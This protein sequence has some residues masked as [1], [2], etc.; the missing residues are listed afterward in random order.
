MQ[1]RLFGAFLVAEGYI[2][3]GQLQLALE[4]QTRLRQARLGDILVARGS[5]PRPML[6]RAVLDQMELSGR[7][8]R[9]GEFLVG[10]GLVRQSDLDGALAHQERERG[11]R[12]GEI[13]IELGFLDSTKLSEAVRRQL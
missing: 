7:R 2:T 10:E 12:L 1:R 3:E 4:H 5:I 8:L 13:I 6:E 9:L 11:K